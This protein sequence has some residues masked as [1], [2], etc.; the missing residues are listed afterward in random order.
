MNVRTAR[1]LLIM[2][3]MVA[4]VGCSLAPTQPSPTSPPTPNGQPRIDY[5]ALEADI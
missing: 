4:V 1:W 5:L 3:F 2:I